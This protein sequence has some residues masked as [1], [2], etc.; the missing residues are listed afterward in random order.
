[1]SELQYGMKYT[2][3]LFK[4]WWAKLFVGLFLI[5]FGFVCFVWPE[6]VTLTAVILFGGLCLLS[7]IMFILSALSG[8]L[9][10]KFRLL[11]LFEGILLFIIGVMTFFWP[12]VTAVTLL[13]LLGFFALLV[14]L[15]RIVDALVMPKEL[16]PMF[17]KVSWAF[18]LIGGILSVIIGILILA[19]PWPSLLAIL[20]LAGAYAIVFGTF[21]FA[22]ALASAKKA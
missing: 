16:R 12:D 10:D 2:G 8:Q 19:Y 11:A 20:W 5:A 22:A 17:G 14:G 4:D 9:G 3:D 15:F 7:G 21:I 1:M 13:Y 6:M 18:L